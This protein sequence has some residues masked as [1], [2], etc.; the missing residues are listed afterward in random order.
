LSDL[1]ES[2]LPSASKWDIVPQLTDVYSVT[3][4]PLDDENSDSGGSDGKGGGGGGGGGGALVCLR[5]A[6]LVRR[7]WRTILFLNDK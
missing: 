3:L 5:E 1:S 2:A 6:K 7:R 4:L